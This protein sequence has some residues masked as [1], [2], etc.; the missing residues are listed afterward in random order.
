[1]KRSSSFR[2]GQSP[3]P[4]MICAST[5]L[6]LVS[7]CILVLVIFCLGT[8]DRWDVSWLKILLKPKHW[9]LRG[10]NNCVR[11]I[12]RYQVLSEFFVFS[13]ELSLQRFME[14]VFFRQISVSTCHSFSAVN[15][16]NCLPPSERGWLFKQRTPF[17]FL[18]SLT[19]S[20][21]RVLHIILCK[22]RW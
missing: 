18:S 3:R 9:L 16:N 11:R 2:L 8:C 17:I 20:C 7:N 5:E 1:M 15:L 10:I 12:S 19:F 4:A 22:A 6:T 13:D 14:N 21:P